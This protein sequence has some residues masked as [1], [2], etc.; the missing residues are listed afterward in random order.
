LRLSDEGNAAVLKLLIVEDNEINLDM[1]VRR[2]RKKFD[3]I[4][5]RSAVEALEKARTES[6]AVVLMDL[7][8]PDIDGLEATRRLRANPAT[9]T[10]PVIAL[11]AQAMAGDRERILA[12]GCDDYEAKPIEDLP[13]LVAKIEALAARNA[14]NAPTSTG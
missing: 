12:A 1:I 6:P 10:L 8:L 2:L 14:A 9:K 3:L 13:R 5:A 4:V 11:T 7:G